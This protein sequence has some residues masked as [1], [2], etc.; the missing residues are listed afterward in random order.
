MYEPPLIDFYDNAILSNGDPRA[1]TVS[2]SGTSS[3]APPFPTSLANVPPGFVLPR[4]SITAVDPDFATQYAWLTN[5]QVE[6]AL[7]SDMSLA[8]ST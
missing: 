4:Q 6:R 2:V 3:G 7:T 5:V 8:I 1:Y